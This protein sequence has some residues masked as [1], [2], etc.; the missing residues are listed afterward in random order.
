MDSESYKSLWLRITELVK[1]YLANAKLTVTEKVARLM[2]TV[3]LCAIVF[4]LG[5]LAFFFLSIALIYWI[6]SG[7]G[8]EW[9]YV[10]MGGFYLLLILV[11]VIFKKQLIVNPIC[12][13]ISQL[14]LS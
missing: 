1:L 4:V 14:L 6:A 13:F 11:L 8:T 10:I 9:A 7:T 5:V 12:K 3:T 2:A